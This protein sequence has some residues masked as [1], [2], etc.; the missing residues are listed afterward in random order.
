MDKS[1]NVLIIEDIEDHA[2]LE[3]R[4]LKTGGYEPI[5]ER[6]ETPA[7]L[8]RVLAVKEWD[9]ILSDY[10]MPA[11][12]GLEALRIVKEHGIDIPFILV[13]G[14]IGEE[15]AV[16]VMKAGGRDYVMKTNLARLAP[17]V[18]R[19]VHEYRQRKSHEKIDNVLKLVIEK[20]NQ[21][22]GDDYFRLL[23][24]QIATILKVRCAMIVELLGEEKKN[25]RTVAFWDGTNFRDSC[26][27]SLKSTPCEKVFLNEDVAFYALNLRAL[28]PD[29]AIIREYGFESYIG[30]P[31]FDA[32]GR[33]IGN[34]AAMH[35]LPLT[36]HQTV[37]D[38]MKVFAARAGAEL[39]R[40]K[41]EESIK[42][43]MAMVN[44]MQLGLFVYRLEDA[45]NDR[46]LTLTIVNPAAEKI[47]GLSA[48]QLL[49]CKIDDTFPLLRRR[50]IPAIFA[51]VARGGPAQA[52]G[53]LPF[54]DA[55]PDSSVFSVRAFPLPDR[56]VGVTF[57]DCSERARHEKQQRLHQQQLIQ[58]DKL[59]SLGILVSG[60]AH[61]INNPNNFILPNARIILRVWQDLEPILQHQLQEHGDFMV[62]GLRYAESRNEIGKIIEGI[63]KGAERIKRI[64]ESLKNYARPDE[65][66][67][68]ESVDINQVVQAAVFLL[69]NLIR[70]STDAFNLN[71]QEPLPPV[72]GSMQQL[73]QVV[74]NLL[75]NACQAQSDRSR[76]I[77]VS[78]QI[79]AGG[80]C[81]AIVVVDHGMGIAPE[82]TLKIFDP[83]FTTKR[84]QGGTG[85]GLPISYRIV[86]SHGG[87]M[88]IQSTPG[89]GT[90]VTVELP[91]PD[92]IPAQAPD[93][94]HG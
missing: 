74:V 3:I 27:Y 40:K 49:G 7:E 4:A 11:L 33:V 39:N 45:E 19:E 17:A 90:T 5:F 10:S 18:T 38:I 35:T 60:V 69:A 23:V 1:I 9:V 67:L 70:K 84:S 41:S 15:K 79:T 46:S 78:T 68:L 37:I 80:N 30:M 65:S 42:Q 32:E 61:E 72:K 24:H 63:G 89:V 57:E 62:A 21:L 59:A 43:Y 75:T 92:T 22:T 77:A 73:E 14:A 54:F 12:D 20:S 88:N 6:V 34:L 93:T 58:A 53:E 81:V 26:D 13:S 56:C 55:D 16:E 86:E 50:E 52:L 28:F 83:F 94:G 25:G 29:N 85:L 82:N 91:L 8:I 48:L 64:V 51:A 47:T 76:E 71:L 87:K 44:N 36:G 66:E 31:L 2:L